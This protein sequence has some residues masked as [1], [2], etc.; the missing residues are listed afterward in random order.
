MRPRIE[1]K[2]EVMS[3]EKSV[4]NRLSIAK[5]VKNKLTTTT[6][7]PTKTPLATPPITNPMRICQLGIGD[8]SISSMAFW[9]FAP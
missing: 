4:S 8:I 6:T 3:I 7:I 5:D 2:A 9:N 1:N